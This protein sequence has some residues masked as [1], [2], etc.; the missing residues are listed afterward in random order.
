MRSS[1]NKISLFALAIIL[2][3]WGCATP[4]QTRHAPQVAPTHSVLMGHFLS[5]VA[6]LKERDGRGA[7][8][9]LDQCLKDSPKHIG[10]RW[11]RGWAHFLEFEFSKALSD[12]KA[13]A[14]HAADIPKLE[15]TL[16]RGE[17]HEQVWKQAQSARKRMKVR[18]YGRLKAA[19]AGNVRIWA[20][21]D[22]MLGSDFP[23]ESEM[24]PDGENPLASFHSDL[25]KATALARPHLKLI[26]YE[27]TLCDVGTTEKCSPGSTVCYAFRTPTRFADYLRDWGV[28]GASLA[29]NHALDFGD[30]CRN[31]TEVA[32]SARGIGYSGRAGS[33]WKTQ[34]SV[35]KRV[36][37]VLYIAFHSSPAYNS[38]LDP[39]AAAKWIGDLKKENTKALI[40]VSFHGGAEGVEA[41]RTPRGMELFHGEKRGDVRNFAHAVIDAGADLVL[42]S[43]PHVLRGM[44]IYKHRLI[45][46]SLGNFA[47]VKSFNLS[48]FNGVSVLL[49][50]DLDR[51]GRFV[52]GRAFPTV[53]LRYGQVRKDPKSRGVDLIRVLSQLDFGKKAPRVA[54]DGSF[55]APP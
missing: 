7:L 55:I 45:A 1:W 12:W 33:V 51:R 49:Q 9:E 11:E 25:E 52:Q 17:L 24:P 2:L 43:G 18:S 26:N 38:T 5:G 28:S 29:N 3:S 23:T 54:R 34:I 39:H 31:Q 10:C 46:Y 40:L 41:V 22:T 48:G 53:Q 16:A 14:E 47:T 13:A 36:R 42:G 6:L 30:E 27:G 35:G 50:V 8:F 20:V 21:G 4:P 37:D 32:L 19:R 15:Q 44:E